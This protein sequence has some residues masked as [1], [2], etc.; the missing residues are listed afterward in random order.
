MSILLLQIRD[1]TIFYLQGMIC[2][3]RFTGGVPININLH[4]DC[5][6]EQELTPYPN[7][8]CLAV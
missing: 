7:L 8:T 4:L 2:T 6:Q 1:T 3:H 5:L